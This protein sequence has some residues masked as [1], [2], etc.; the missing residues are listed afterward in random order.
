MFS[1]MPSQEFLDARTRSFG[2]IRRAR[3]PNALLHEFARIIAPGIDCDEMVLPAP[4]NRRAHFPDVIA[5]RQRHLGSSGNALVLPYER[6]DPLSLFEVIRICAR[7]AHGNQRLKR[8]YGITVAGVSFERLA[9]EV[10][11]ELVRDRE[12]IER[13][14]AIRTLIQ[15]ESFATV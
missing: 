8:D 5:A 13:K 6:F 4:L 7:F 9:R 10:I 2:P 14:R 15:R 3:P 11:A 1:S 12:C